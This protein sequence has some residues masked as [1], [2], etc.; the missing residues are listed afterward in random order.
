MIAAAAD[1]YGTAGGEP[2][3]DRADPGGQGPSPTISDLAQLSRALRTRVVRDI[4]RRHR[5]G[6]EGAAT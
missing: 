2:P 6:S 4:R 5:L 1:A 3:G